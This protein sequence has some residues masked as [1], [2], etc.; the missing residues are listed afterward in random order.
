ME[1]DELT[2]DYSRLEGG[3]VVITRTSLASRGTSYVS[4]YMS[5]PADVCMI[6]R[7]LNAVLPPTA[8][9][10]STANVE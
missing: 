5:A 9:A 8:D 10:H 3:G 4:R 2:H 1:K 6:P 7:I